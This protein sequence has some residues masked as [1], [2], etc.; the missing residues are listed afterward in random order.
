[1]KISRP[2][3]A[4]AIASCF[5]CSGS[6]AAETKFPVIP[7]T[8]GIHVIQAEVAATEAD[9]AQGL[10]HRQA[11]GANEG[12]LFLFG[13]PA[14]VC[15]WMKN[16]PLPLSVAFLDANGLI[17]NIEDMTPNTATS[18]CANKRANYALEMRQGWFKQKNV[19]PG[20][21]IKGLPR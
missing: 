15:M 7:L 9:R 21:A 18:H 11:L 4:T 17:I 3:F 5:L 8:A 19:K 1:M 14:T 2:F 6:V 12:M 20:T 16:T 10:M 13:A